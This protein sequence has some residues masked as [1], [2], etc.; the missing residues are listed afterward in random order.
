MGLFNDKN[1]IWFHIC[2]FLIYGRTQFKNTI[3]KQHKSNFKQ[4]SQFCN[5]DL[6]AKSK[7]TTVKVAQKCVELTLDSHSYTTV[8]KTFMYTFGRFKRHEK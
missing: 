1:L 8:I 2:D 4:L 3:L 6:L 5:C 7:K